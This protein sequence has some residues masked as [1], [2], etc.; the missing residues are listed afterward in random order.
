MGKNVYNNFFTEETWNVVNSENKELVDDYLMEL[1]QNKKADT[2]IK[3]YKNDLRIILIFIYN[4]L[5]NKSIL[6]LNKKDF[7]RFSLWLT[8][9]KKLSAARHNRLMSAIRSLLTYAENDDDYDYDNNVAKKVRGLPSESV[10]EIIFLTDEEIIKL[11]DELVSRREFQKAS[12]LALAYD[13]CARK[14]ELAQVNKH[15]FYDPTK[16]N[17]NKVVGK[18]RKIFTLLYFDMTKECVNLWLNQRGEDNIDSLWVVGSEENKSPASKDLMYE[19]FVWMRG[20]ME[21]ISGKRLDFNVHSIRHASLQNMSDGSHYICKKLGMNDGFPIEKL[22][23][24]ANHSDVSTT[25]SYLKDNSL[26]E[27]E[28]MF[29][30]EI[31]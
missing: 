30:I 7:R 10:R 5:E 11:K 8:E 6:E 18:R 19:W 25:S 28:N 29:G 22:R 15:S 26:N 17:T 3:Q 9:E 20:V 2:T 13:S 14:A 27:L 21:D 12:V 31:V 16:N 23:I 24:F 1:K 4:F